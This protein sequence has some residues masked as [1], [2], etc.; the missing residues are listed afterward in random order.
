M[1]EALGFKVDGLPEAL[2]KQVTRSSDFDFISHEN[3]SAAITGKTVFLLRGVDADVTAFLNDPVLANLPAVKEKQVY[4]LGAT[5][6][7]ID[8]YS[9]IQLIDIVAAHFRK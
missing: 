6:F 9:G 5:S 8:Y 4:P 3:M 7:R 2:A 1:L